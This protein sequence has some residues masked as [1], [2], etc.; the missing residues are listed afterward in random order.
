VASE[1]LLL[2]FVLD[3]LNDQQPTDVVDDIVLIEWVIVN[4]LLV[5]AIVAN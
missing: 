3:V 2:V 5:L 1:E 4:S